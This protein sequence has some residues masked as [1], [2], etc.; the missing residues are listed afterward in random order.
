MSTTAISS[1]YAPAYNWLKAAANRT[2]RMAFD[3]ETS[4]AI[5]KTVVDTCAG[6]RVPNARLWNRT[7]GQ[8]WGSFFKATHQSFKD[9]P[10]EGGL[11]VFKNVWNSLKGIPGAAKGKIGTWAK[12]KA[13][14]GKLGPLAN[15]ALIVGFEIPNLYRAF[16]HKDG[17]VVTGAV[18]TGKAT[19]KLGASMAGFAIGSAAG[20]IVGAKAGALIGTAICPGLGSFVGG[21]IGFIGGMVGSMIAGKVTDKLLGKSFSEKVEEKESNHFTLAGTS[22]NNP[23]LSGQVPNP[24]QYQ[25][26][27]G[28]PFS[29]QQMQNFISLQQMY[30]EYMNAQRA[31]GNVPAYGGRLSYMY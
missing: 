14:G 17:G 22:N 20:G 23:A 10:A 27:G 28:N 4:N 29:P 31:L 18:E 12:V 3:L 25:F 30:Q 7:G 6:T 9:I 26:A 24:Y 5:T 11:N 1:S 2:M 15:L 13:V 16:T 19:I 21:A 8:G